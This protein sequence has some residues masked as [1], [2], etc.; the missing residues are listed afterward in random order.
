[1]SDKISSEWVV[2]T[3]VSYA[4]YME[5]Y[6]HNH[7]EWEGGTVV[8]MAPIH[9]Q[10]DMLARYFTRMFEA[11]LELRPIGKVRTEPFVMRLPQISAAREPDIMVILNDNSHQYTPTA[12]LGSAD[13]C[14]EIVSPENI[15]R[16]YQ[17]KKEEYEQ[18]GVTEYWIIDWLEQRCTFY[19]QNVKGI[20][21][22]QT[23]DDSETY[24]SEVLPKLSIHVPSL[25]QK[26]LPGPIAI[27]Q[28][29][30]DML[31]R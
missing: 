29:V 1:M 28:S 7:H 13:L 2:A 25:W 10:H 24:F 15:E 20:Y 17:T 5:H 26:N 19:L 11:Y 23:L 22:P 21:I 14:V 27:G 9:D 6:A 3:N 18:S 16:D 8:K 31:N 12:M 4:D 30:Q